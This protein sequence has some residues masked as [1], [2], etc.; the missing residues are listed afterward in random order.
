[1]LSIMLPLMAG[2]TTKKNSKTL[3][4]ATYYQVKELWS[5]LPSQLICAARIK[6]TE[7]LKAA[8]TC[9]KQGKK[10]SQPKSKL[11][12]IRY[13]QRSYRVNWTK[14]QVSLATAQG[15]QFLNFEVAG[16]AQKYTKYPVDSADLLYRKGNFWLHVV[17]SLPDPNFITIGLSLVI[18]SE[19]KNLSL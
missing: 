9:R 6:A 19:A 3:H 1:M 2:N 13:D 12:P 15:R 18:L 4:K 8:F 11:C 17:V 5:K 14:H 16:H 10:V 7:T